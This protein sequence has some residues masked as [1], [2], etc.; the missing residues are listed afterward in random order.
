MN[1][2]AA[3]RRHKE[4]KKWLNENYGWIADQYDEEYVAIWEKEIVANGETIEEVKDII[5]QRRELPS[6]DE[7]AIEFVSRVPQGLLL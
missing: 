3:I 2:L 7:V 1:A 5:S 4:D 6:P